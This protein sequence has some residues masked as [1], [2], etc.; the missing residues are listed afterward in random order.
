VSITR[1]CFYQDGGDYKYQTTIDLPGLF[2]DIVFVGY[3]EM[4]PQ[5]DY[6]DIDS[7][8]KYISFAKSKLKTYK[9]LSRFCRIER[10]PD[11]TQGE[12]DRL[13]FHTMPPSFTCVIKTKR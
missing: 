9:S 2:S 1:H 11:K 6:R 13:V 5:T 7:D 12:C 3:L 4:N 10:N 8:K